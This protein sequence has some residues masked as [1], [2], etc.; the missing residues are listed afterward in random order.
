MT[1][2]RVWFLLRRIDEQ[3]SLFFPL[4]VDIE[5]HEPALFGASIFGLDG[6]LAAMGRTAEEAEGSAVAMFKDIVDLAFEKNVPLGKELGERVPFRRVKVTFEKADEFFADFL[7]ALSSSQVEEEWRSV[8]TTAL[9]AAASP[10]VG[11][12]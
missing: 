5:E 8:P 6:R 9:V 12:A 11:G 3:D 2:R 1:A 7:E 4:V 10:A